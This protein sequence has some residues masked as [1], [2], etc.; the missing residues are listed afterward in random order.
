MHCPNQQQFAA[1]DADFRRDLCRMDLEAARES[2]CC[3]PSR[4]AIL[5]R[6]VVSPKIKRELSIMG[7]KCLRKSLS[8]KIA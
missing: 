7:K 5:W 4:G 3:T 6:L 8:E 2:D 1:S